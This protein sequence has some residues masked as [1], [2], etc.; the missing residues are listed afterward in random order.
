MLFAHAGGAFPSL[1]GRIDNGYQRREEPK[2]VIK[3]LPST[4]AHRVYYDSI[5]HDR[6]ILGYMC[7]KYGSN[8]VMMGS[9]YPFDMGVLH[10][11]DQVIDAGLSEEDLDNVLF[12]TAEEFM[13][14]RLPA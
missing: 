7:R 3:T 10:P 8:R 4:F 6:E 9:D 12:R 2:R 11:L 1:L 13:G 5:T 14:I